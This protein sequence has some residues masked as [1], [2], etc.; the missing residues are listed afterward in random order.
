[1]DCVDLDYHG[2]CALCAPG[3]GEPV[4]EEQAKDIHGL[5]QP[6]IARLTQKVSHRPRIETNSALWRAHGLGNTGTAHD[7]GRRP[8]QRNCQC[9]HQPG[10]RLPWWRRI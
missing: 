1:M 6:D 8:R 4:S 3:P 2:V 7:L 9:I 5:A 10:W